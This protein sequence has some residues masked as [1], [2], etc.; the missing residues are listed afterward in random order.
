MAKC[1]DPKK[2]LNI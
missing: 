2:H 1:F